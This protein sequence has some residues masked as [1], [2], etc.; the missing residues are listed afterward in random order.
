MWWVLVS[1]DV[2]K[3][4]CCWLHFHATITALMNMLLTI[5]GEGVFSLLR[6]YWTKSLEAA[7]LNRLLL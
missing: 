2:R 7:L 3:E 1:E 4:V 6:I 5:E